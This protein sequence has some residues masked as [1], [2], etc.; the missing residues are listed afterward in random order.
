MAYRPYPSPERA[1]HQLDRHAD[2]TGPAQPTRPATPMERQLAD[3]LTVFRQ[4]MRAAQPSWTIV[5]ERMRQG[6]QPA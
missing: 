2:E 3:M 4:R 1:R 5:V 6:R